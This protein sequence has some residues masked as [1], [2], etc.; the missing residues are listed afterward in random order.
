[1]WVKTILF[2]FD[3]NGQNLLHRGK[4]HILIYVLIAHVI[5]KH[6]LKF[7]LTLVMIISHYDHHS[8]VSIPGF[9]FSF[10]F[11]FVM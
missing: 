1:M 8:Y 2:L 9:F 3:T 11:N 7:Q 5:L 4:K 6:T 10:F